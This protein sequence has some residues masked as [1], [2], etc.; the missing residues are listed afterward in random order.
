MVEDGEYREIVGYIVER[1]AED[2]G[3]ANAQI[4]KSNKDT[5]FVIVVHHFFASK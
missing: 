5:T 4:N 1:N 2:G 3:T